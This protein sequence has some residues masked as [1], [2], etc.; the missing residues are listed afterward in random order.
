MYTLLLRN[1]QSFTRTLYVYAAHP[2]S[3]PG[4][5]L[6]KPRT[7]SLQPGK[8]ENAQ[9]LREDVAP[10]PL[11]RPDLS[12]GSAQTQ[13]RWGCMHGGRVGISVS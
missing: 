7:P 3:T 12:L 4:Y 1:F 11:R 9:P 2:R 5:S 10:P 8:A 6:T 13:P